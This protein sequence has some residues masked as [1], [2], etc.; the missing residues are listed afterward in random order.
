M[1][2]SSYTKT[3]R[4]LVLFEIQRLVCWKYSCNLSRKQIFRIFRWKYNW[5]KI[6]LIEEH[7]IL[8]P[9]LRHH[10][11]RRH[12]NSDYQGTYYFQLFTS[13]KDNSFQIMFY[14]WKMLKHS[15]GSTRFHFQITFVTPLYKRKTYIILNF[16]T[17]RWINH[18]LF[19]FS[20]DF[21]CAI[22]R[23]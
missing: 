18:F 12:I 1:V 16:V 21:A 5:Q 20:M 6:V 11:K 4:T 9:K 19:I 7:H 10:L 23:S 8:L 17:Y 15:V 14:I 3:Q 13:T 22:V 2:S